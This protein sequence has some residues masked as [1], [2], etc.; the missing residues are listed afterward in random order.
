MADQ[1]GAGPQ[2]GDELLQLLQT[3]EVEV[4]GRLVEQE[5][6][7]AAEQQGGEPGA[8]RLAARQRVHLQVEADAEA[9]RGGRLLGAF[10]QIGAAEREPALQAGRVGVVGAGCLV[11]E[12]L[13]GGVEFGLRGGDPGPAGEELADRL[14][15]GRRS[16]S[17]GRCPTVAVAG[18]SRRLPSSGTARPAS[19][20]SSVD[21]PAPLAP[22]RPTTSPGATTRSSPEKSVRSPCP[23]ARFL[24]TRVALIRPRTL[25]P[26]PAPCGPPTESPPGSA[27]R[28]AA[29]WPA[30]QIA[31]VCRG[32]CRGKNAS[33]LDCF[34][35]H[36]HARP[37]RPGK[38]IASHRAALSPY[39]T[40][41]GV[42]HGRSA[43]RHDSAR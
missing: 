37:A 28:Q 33:T 32:G 35:A 12:G 27:H 3:V 7:V 9:E 8:G 23:A 38:A 18:L 16:G 34:W 42:D 5:D 6:V 17:C 36:C 21:F 2:A 22:T 4:V 19:S 29:A 11:D 43:L 25:S 41:R 10:L 30:R 40:V 15:P 26:T 1:Y 13:G 31:A 39:G 14:T 24:A 20:R